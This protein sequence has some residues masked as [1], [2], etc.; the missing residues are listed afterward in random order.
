MTITSSMSWAELAEQEPGLADFGQ[1]RIDGKVAY[2]AT[3]RKSGQ[4]RAHPVTP[5]IGAGRC[6]IFV[7]PGTSKAG[8][9]QENGYYCLHCAMN[10]SSGSS[11]EFQ[12]SGVA[13]AI[14]DEETRRLAESVSSYRPSGRSLLFELKVSEAVSTQYRGG[15]PRRRKWTAEC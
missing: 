2:L 3:V 7:E 4:P 1:V 13:E 14:E 6:F 12:I 15:Q 10:D 11:G 8:D 9:L 5:I